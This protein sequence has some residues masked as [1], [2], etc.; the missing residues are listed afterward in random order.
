MEENGNIKIYYRLILFSGN[1]KKGAKPEK[2]NL[3]DLT[4][5]KVR[6]F[7]SSDEAERQERKEKERKHEQKDIAQ[8]S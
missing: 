8:V 4:H 1:R 7:H 5:S 6:R 2:E 3:G